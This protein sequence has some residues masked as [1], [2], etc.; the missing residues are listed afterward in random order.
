MAPSDSAPAHVHVIAYVDHNYW[1]SSPA[2]AALACTH[3]IAQFVN[4][5]A[6]THVCIPRHRWIALG[7]LVRGSGPPGCGAPRQG[8]S[9]IDPP[10]PIGINNLKTAQIMAQMTGAPASFH[11]YNQDRRAIMRIEYS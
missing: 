5:L 9:S 3:G 11:A 4:S 7:S 2:A 8:G 6:N 10:I 1:H